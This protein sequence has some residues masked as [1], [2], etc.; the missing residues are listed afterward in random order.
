ML[1]S[2]TFFMLRIIAHIRTMNR[3]RARRFIITYIIY[4]A[5]TYTVL[6]VWIGTSYLTL[7]CALYNNV[8]DNDDEMIILY[9]L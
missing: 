8:Y 4:L 5:C 1:K 9:R 7:I 6:V 2:T 3:F